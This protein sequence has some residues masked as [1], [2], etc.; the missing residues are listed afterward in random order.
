MIAHLESE[1]LT[2]RFYT[3]YLRECR[4]ILR[5]RS[6]WFQYRFVRFFLKKIFPFI[7]LRRGQDVL[8]VGSAA[9]TLE[10]G[11]SQAI[12][13][14][15]IVG[16]R[17]HVLVLEPEAKNRQALIEYALKHGIHNIS[18]VPLAACNERGTRKLTVYGGAS[19]AHVLGEALERRQ[20][21][22]EAASPRT[23]R[24]DVR[25]VE[26]EVDTID[27]VLEEREYSPDFIN[28]TTNGSEF[29]V[30]QGMAETLK[31]RIT[32][33][34][35]IFG[36]RGWFQAAFDLLDR[37]GF[38]I[39]VCDAPPTHRGPGIDGMPRPLRRRSQVPQRLVAMA[40]KNLDSSLGGRL[41]EASLVQD[42]SSKTI[43]IL[44]RGNQASLFSPFAQ[45]PDGKPS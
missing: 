21:T 40:T 28:L 10:A 6:Y 16:P 27:H 3:S 36:P 4:L 33:S 8:Q 18:V 2:A 19:G 24:N 39:V 25:E 38:D 14:S 34:F 43:R 17:G 13:L 15:V 31:R 32:V 30:I 37:K 29:E 23:A 5:T 20:G 22:G 26:I 1:A 35:P 44:R 41:H 42:E 11:I 45:E 7:S 12:A 9:W